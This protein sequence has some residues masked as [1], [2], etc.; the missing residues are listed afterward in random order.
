MFRNKKER[1]KTQL[2]SQLDFKLEHLQERK[3]KKQLTDIKSSIG[4]YQDKIKKYKESIE[5]LNKENERIIE[6]NKFLTQLRDICSKA[7]SLDFGK[8]KLI[9]V[10]I[11]E[12]SDSI[13]SFEE[14]FEIF[15]KI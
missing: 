2:N 9:K 6:I 5:K 4:Q 12:K 13:F 3:G 15:S 10:T 14:L 7:S 8:E 1:L 11:K